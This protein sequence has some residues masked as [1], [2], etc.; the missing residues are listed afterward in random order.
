MIIYSRKLI[1]NARCFISHLIKINQQ[2]KKNN[3]QYFH[4]YCDY[5]KILKIFAYLTDVDKN[6]GPHCFVK[7]TYIKKQF[8][9]VLSKR[10]DNN[11][12]LNNYSTKN[13]REF[14][15]PKG[16]IIFEDTFGL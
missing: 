5:K 2:V 9:H 6:S 10:I 12:I 15:E 11:K 13:Y 3:A 16:S 8:K 1:I 14:I 7:S 4:Y